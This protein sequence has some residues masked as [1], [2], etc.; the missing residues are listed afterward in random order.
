MHCT[1]VV[2]G[3][4]EGGERGRV[5]YHGHAVACR[6]YTVH[7][8]QSMTGKDVQS[9]VEPSLADRARLAEGSA[10]VREGAL[11]CGV[12]LGRELERDLLPDLR[13]KIAR[14]ERERAVCP[15]RNSVRRGGRGRSASCGS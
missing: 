12:V 3:D 7:T 13:G 11:G 4:R 1:Y 9:G 6:Q 5:R 15:N 2:D 8:K 14:L 10:W